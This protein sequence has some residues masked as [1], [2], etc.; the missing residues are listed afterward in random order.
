MLF[1]ELRTIRSD[2]NR[3]IKKVEALASAIAAGEAEPVPQP[4]CLAPASG[5]SDATREPLGCEEQGGRER[6][7]VGA[8]F[9]DARPGIPKRRF[10][11]RSRWI[12][13]ISGI[14]I[15]GSLVVAFPFCGDLFMS[16]QRLP[17]TTLRKER[18]SDAAVATAANTDGTSKAAQVIEAPPAKPALVLSE[19]SAG[20]LPEVKEETLS[21][22]R[23]CTSCSPEV[24]IS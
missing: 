6:G 22:P 23:R 13:V 1:G 3:Q 17:T 21:W 10:W 4:H 19:P 12:L 7:R 5:A 9:R 16:Q 14:L 2:L 11:V 8:A 20:R 18:R 15:I 24:R